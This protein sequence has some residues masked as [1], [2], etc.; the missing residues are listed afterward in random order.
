MCVINAENPHSF[1]V[2]PVVEFEDSVEDSDCR[3][4]STA[5]EGAASP[6]E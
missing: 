2:L 4:D 3:D 5:D 1:L 6:F